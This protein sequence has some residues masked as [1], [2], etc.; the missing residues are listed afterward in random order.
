ML[1][2][3]LEPKKWLYDNIATGIFILVV[4]SS[5][6]WLGTNVIYF[7]CGL[8][9]IP[10]ELYEAAD[11]DGASPVQRLLH[12]TIPG[13]RPILIFVITVV[14]YGGLRMFGES[15]VMWTNGSIPGDVG[16]T[17]RSL[18]LQNGIYTF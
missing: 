13:L 1:F 11:I 14:T 3:G 8:Q 18:Y 4:T 9:S 7:L 15:F 17:D 12:V 5:W 6:R 10:N 16:L 2:L